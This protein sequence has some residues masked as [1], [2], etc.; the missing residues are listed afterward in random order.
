[1]STHNFNE[2]AFPTIPLLLHFSKTIP[3]SIVK[4]DSCFAFSISQKRIVFS[5]LVFSSH[6]YHVVQPPHALPQAFRFDCSSL[7]P[8]T[9]WRSP[10]AWEPHL[11][12]ECR[13]IYCKFKKDGVFLRFELFFV[14]GL[15]ATL[16]VRFC[17][18]VGVEGL[19]LNSTGPPSPGS[20]FNKQWRG[21][22]VG[23]IMDPYNSVRNSNISTFYIFSRAFTLHISWIPPR[24][25]PYIFGEF[26]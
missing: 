7:L 11:K 18:S 8:Y 2:F 26:L 4:S 1:M 23:P 17:D 14:A 15:K 16:H 12:P 10:C 5:S 20:I 13:K 21:L 25:G 19:G 6:R 9:G 24:H 22:P 3:L